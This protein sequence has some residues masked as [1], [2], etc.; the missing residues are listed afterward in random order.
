MPF[1]SVIIPTYSRKHLVGRAVDSVLHQSYPDFEL[2]VVDDASEDGTDELE[3]FSGSNSRV[4]YLR[5]PLH[6]GVAAARNTGVSRSTGAWICFLDSDDVWHKDK[7]QKQVSWHE[8]HKEFRI[9]QTQEIWIRKGVRVNPPKTHAKIHGYQ[10]RENLE[11][12]M[13]TP[14]S[15]MMEKRLFLE[16]GGFNESLPACEDYDL[17][18]RITSA[19]PVGLIDEPL[20]TRFGGHDDQLSGVVPILDRFRIRSIL[21]IL[22]SKKL[23]KEQSDL[24]RSQLIK[25]ALIVT[26]GF[27]KRGKKN[28][29]ETYQRLAEKY[30]KEAPSSGFAAYFL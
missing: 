29:Y 30:K 22:N 19:Y 26:N 17:W 12:C 2:I 5:L 21:D 1:I 20:L 10:F 27:K 18:L 7:L 4:N 3:Y 8:T 9:F 28:D 24:A 6:R 15:V 13:I 16:S 11:R 14:S 25:K 23:S